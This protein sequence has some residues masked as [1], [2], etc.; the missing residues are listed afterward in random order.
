MLA[1]TT[2][3]DLFKGLSREVIHQV[4]YSMK[5]SH[6]GQNQ[7]ITKVGDKT[8][9]MIL[10][11]GKLR[12]ETVANGT[13]LTL[14]EMGKGSV[15]NYENMFMTDARSAV[16]ITAIRKCDI[17]SITLDQLKKF[18]ESH[19]NCTLKANIKKQE[20]TIFKHL[21]TKNQLSVPLDFCCFLGKEQPEIEASRKF[22]NIVLSMLKEIR[23]AQADAKRL[24]LKH[25]IQ[26]YK[27]GYLEQIT[28]KRKEFLLESAEQ[29]DMLSNSSKA[30][31]QL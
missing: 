27:K 31:K 24:P 28:E 1:Y 21:M 9:L 10:V 25:M 16:I 30:R 13:F 4:I 5:V 7:T 17:I 20:K 11:R 29:L 6:Y 12:I 22:K 23:P 19:C 3:L 26:K 8:D 15:L 2:Q 14:S 18:G